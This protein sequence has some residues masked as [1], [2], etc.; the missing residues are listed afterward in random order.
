[1][2]S[3]LSAHF[4]LICVCRLD[5]ERRG[6]GMFGRGTGKEDLEPEVVAE[7]T[8][9]AEAVEDLREVSSGCIGCISVAAWGGGGG[10]GAPSRERLASDGAG[11]GSLMA[12][13]GVGVD[14]WMSE[15]T[16]WGEKVGRRKVGGR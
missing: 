5:S 1:L 14:G 16:T 4:V 7:A 10:G 3:F 6:L 12:A 11:S 15:Q 13:K 2:A 9:E 8:V